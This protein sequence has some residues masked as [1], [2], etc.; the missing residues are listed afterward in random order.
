MMA[1]S[2]VSPDN[3]N[4]M[5]HF[6]IVVDVPKEGTTIKI[7]HVGNPHDKVLIEDQNLSSFPSGSSLIVIRPKNEELAKELVKVAHDTSDH[8]NKLKG[9]VDLTKS[10]TNFKKFT[11]VLR[12]IRKFTTI[13][14]EK[15]VIAKLARIAVDSHHVFY[16]KD[17]HTPMSMSCA[18]YAS[19]VINA[20][21]LRIDK[22]CGK[23]INDPVFL[24]LIEQWN[25]REPRHNALK[26][27]ISTLEDNLMELEIEYEK[28]SKENEKAVKVIEEGKLNKKELKLLARE[29]LAAFNENS[30]KITSKIKSLTNDIKSKKS[31]IDKDEVLLSKLHV[32]R[33]E[34]IKILTSKLNVKNIKEKLKGGGIFHD[35]AST[36]GLADMMLAHPE[37]WEFKGF[38]GGK[39][40]M[41][42]K[43]FL[44]YH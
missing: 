7:A 8:G 16:R 14:D 34:L 24:E 4:R 25:K 38:L 33:N 26:A 2:F 35:Q 40:Q 23:I 10:P 43:K 42:N 41:R 9:F 1:Q 32:K 3:L 15:K 21:L 6:E 5:L 18:Q 22:E 31:E 39:M 19:N 28:I 30:E 12:F 29:Q 36:S 11:K 37:E 27:E 20:S 17:G 44:L 13:P